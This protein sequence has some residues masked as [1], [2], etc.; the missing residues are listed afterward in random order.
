MCVCDLL[1]EHVNIYKQFTVDFFVLNFSFFNPI[2]K[3]TQKLQTHEIIKKTH[4]AT[5]QQTV[6]D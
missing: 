3:P 2:E 5:N 4:T 1:S 6:V